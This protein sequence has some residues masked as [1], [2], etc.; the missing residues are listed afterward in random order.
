MA[1]I[2]EDEGSVNKLVRK[3]AIE[4]ALHETMEGIINRK[5]PD[6]APSV[7]AVAKLLHKIESYDTKMDLMTETILHIMH[8]KW[9]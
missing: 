6:H 4:A 7:R 5:I 1:H 8:N 2:Y 3:R 9:R